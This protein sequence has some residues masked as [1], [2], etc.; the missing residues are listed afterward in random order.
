MNQNRIMI[1]MRKKQLL[2][3]RMNHQMKRDL[4]MMSKANRHQQ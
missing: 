3:M 2:K 4:M 1:Q